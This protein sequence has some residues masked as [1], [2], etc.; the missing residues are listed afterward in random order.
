MQSCLSQGG[1]FDFCAISSKEL[2]SLKYEGELV[3]YVEEEE[4]GELRW[5]GKWGWT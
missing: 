2:S 3:C 4:N 1:N 5:G